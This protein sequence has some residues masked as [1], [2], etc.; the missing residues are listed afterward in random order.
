MTSLRSRIRHLLDR[1]DNARRRRRIAP[2]WVRYNLR[3]ALAD[4]SPATP[5]DD[6]PGPVRRAIGRLIP[7]PPQT[8][9][10]IEFDF[11]R[12]AA[13][14]RIEGVVLDLHHGASLAGQQALQ[15]EIAKLRAAGKRVVGYATT[16]GALRYFTACA[17]ERIAMPPN[18][19]WSVL[20]FSSETVFFKE[21]LDWLGVE[22]ETTRVSDYKSAT[23]PFTRTDYSTAAREQAERLLDARFDAVCA[24]IA[25]S[26]GIPPAR[27]RELIDGAPYTA[28]QA[29]AFGLIDAVAHEDELQELLVEGSSQPAEDAGWSRWRRVREAIL[30]PRRAWAR[31]R[32]R[33]ALLDYGDARRSL[34]VPLPDYSQTW[35]A[36]VRV[37]GTLIQG[38]SSPASPLP[39]P[40]AGDQLCGHRSV[41][42]A[43]RRAERDDDTG[44]IILAIDSPGG[45]ALASELIAREVQRIKRRKPIIACMTSV[46]ASGGYMV[47]AHANHIIAEPLTVTG[48]IGVFGTKFIDQGLYDRL[49]LHR[50]TLRRGARS[51][52]YD[53]D[54][55]SSPEFR[56][57]LQQGT[58][59][60]YQRFK[61][62]VAEGRGLTDDNLEPLCGGRV[63]TGEEAHARGLV[64]AL[65][66]FPQAMAWAQEN[67]RPSD[68]KRL[69][70]WVVPQ[71]TPYR[72]PKPFP[73]GAAGLSAWLRSTWLPQGDG[74][75]HERSAVPVLARLPFDPA[76]YD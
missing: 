13:D 1:V 29:L 25:A 22:V 46:A 3:N 17:C 10:G 41:I 57:A 39:L 69:D 2:R 23:E 56:E 27:V 67:V 47:A 43:L 35:V 60:V 74:A 14:P 62:V 21:A 5:F 50:T 15:R 66:G 68:G 55:P 31:A 36:V 59:Q 38:T 71:D 64:D 19:E 30:H 61:A 76:V 72:L 20:G 70:W 7:D 37:E 28:E 44:A 18:G 53:S 40:F 8:L 16:F 9:R 54:A 6:L 63:W 32:K 33:P 48:S 12:I 51:G 26:R 73:A 24:A 52:M 75:A 34:L 11:E 49:R 4:F 45:D 65:G 42:A 58:E